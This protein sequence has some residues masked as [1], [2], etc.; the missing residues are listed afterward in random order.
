ML[1][2]YYLEI[3]V[4]IN[5][6]ADILPN[7]I[8]KNHK[9]KLFESKKV[10]FIQNYKPLLEQKTDAMKKY[11]NKYFIK[12]FIRLNLSAIA[13]PVLLVRKQDDRLKFYIDY[14]A[15]NK[16]KVKNWYPIPL[17]NKIL[18]KLSNAAYFTKLD[19]IYVFN[20]IWIKKDKK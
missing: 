13:A 10:L 18:E 17:I 15:F 8:P 5:Q 9:I 3:K 1:K 2:E 20:R 14:R 19:I 4:F 16:I 11:I 7:H 12:S 6:D